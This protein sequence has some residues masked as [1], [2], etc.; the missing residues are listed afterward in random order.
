[1][2]DM[3]VRARLFASCLIL[4]M[5]VACGSPPPRQPEALDRA[6]KTEQA[7]YRAMREGDLPRARELFAQA[8]TMQQA[9][10]NIADASLDTINLA[11]VLH[12]LGKDAD[13][14]QALHAILTEAN[15]LVTEDMKAAAAFRSAVILL[16]GNRLQEAADSITL[17]NRY[18]HNNC[19]L[20]P[21]LKNLQ[22]RIALQQEKPEEALAL[23]SQVIGNGSMPEEQANANRTAAM[24]ALVLNKPALA[25]QYYETALQLDKSLALSGRIAEDLEGSAAALQ[26]LGKPELA[27]GFTQRAADVRSAYKLLQEHSTSKSVR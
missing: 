1:M 27:A 24:A 2:I 26:K 7:A 9:L 17:A 4:L 8:R 15:H 6:R 5:L 21:G 16:D 22:A 18:C 10:E 12:K 20:Q 11:T 3:L 14:L 25:L 23:A 13:A 19:V